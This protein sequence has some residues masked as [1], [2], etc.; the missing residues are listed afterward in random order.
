MGKGRHILLPPRNASIEEEERS[1]RFV[2]YAIVLNDLYQWITDIFENNKSL[3]WNE[4]VALSNNFLTILY[5]YII[6]FDLIYLHSTPF[7]W[8]YFYLCIRVCMNVCM[9]PS[10]WVPMEARRRYHT[11]GTVLSGR[12]ELPNMGSGNH[13][14]LLYEETSTLNCWADYSPP[15]LFPTHLP[16]IVL[17]SLNISLSLVWAAHMHV[18]VGTFIGSWATSQDLYPQLPFFQQTLSTNMSSA[19]GE[20][21]CTLP[22]LR[23]NCWSRAMHVQV[24]TAA[25]SP[26]V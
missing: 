17:F 7:V 12:C 21:L 14:Q 20:V 23:L 8:T 15:L 22:L 3:H 9:L 2:L 26:C 1:R 11:P 19:R 6:Y 16:P 4:L 24:T 5:R 13:A 10:K 25:V 18:G